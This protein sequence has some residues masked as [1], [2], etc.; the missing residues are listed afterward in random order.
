MNEILEKFKKS[1]GE[2]SMLETDSVLVGFSGGG[3]SSALLHILKSYC[4]K[5]SI[6]LAAV[7]I[8][9]M[10]RGEEAD[11]DEAFCRDFCRGLNIEFFAVREDIP[12]LAQREKKGLEE[13]A[14]DFRYSVFDKICREEGISTVATAHNGDDNLETVLFNLARGCGV[15]GICGIPP[16][17]GNIIRPLITCTKEEILDYCREKGV[18]YIYD[19]TNS[20]TDYTRNYIRH[21]LIP[22]MKKLNPNV[23]QSVAVTSRGA[24]QSLYAIEDGI[25]RGLW[26][27]DTAPEGVKVRMIAREY[28]KNGGAE[29]GLESCHYEAILELIKNKEEGSMVSL[30]GR[31]RGRICKGELVFER[32][33]REKTQRLE[34]RYAL[35]LGVTLIP[36][37]DL[38]V[39]IL[40][41]DEKSKISENVYNLTMKA[42]LCFGTIDDIDGLYVRPRQDGDKYRVGGMTRSVKKLLWEMEL[43]AEEKLNYPIVCDSEGIVFLP[44]YRLR[45]G[46]KYRKGLEYTVNVYFGVMQNDLE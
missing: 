34:G 25:D 8:N 19:S 18:P 41:K 35:G 27:M 24:R 22:H 28:Q 33:P 23:S 3:D 5:R 13:C 6:R 43:S 20:D 17:R 1:V 21:N 38:A 30:P 14:R 16:V 2:Y 37:L 10:I 40:P 31:L 12:A 9:H 42:M 4:E 11:R 39:E 36:E 45:D 29:G 32:D 44:G 15:G 26:Q 46:E 7:H